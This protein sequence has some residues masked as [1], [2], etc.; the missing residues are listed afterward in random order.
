VESPYRII[1]KNVSTK[2][3]VFAQRRLPPGGKKSLDPGRRREGGGESLIKYLRREANSLSR[4]TRRPA[5]GV[6]GGTPALRELAGS[7][8]ARHD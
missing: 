4:G 5:L 1:T 6:G 8:A 7:S 2:A 3:H